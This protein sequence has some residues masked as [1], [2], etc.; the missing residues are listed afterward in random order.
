MMSTWCHR[1]CRWGLAIVLTVAVGGTAHAWVIPELVGRY[2]RHELAERGFP[3]AQLH[4]KRVGVD[5]VQ[6]TN[7]TLGDGMSLGEVELD[8]GW[9]LLWRP[10]HALTIRGA[11]IS[12][13]AIERWAT[14]GSA[15]SGAKTTSGPIARLPIAE[16]RLAD[17]TVD[18][19][20][21]RFTV[22]GAV[23]LASSAVHLRAHTPA[24]DV[25]PLALRSVSITA[26]DT[27]DSIRACASGQIDGI[28]SVEGCTTVP[29]ASL[30]ATRALDVEWS[31]SSRMGLVWDAQGRGHVAWK[32]AGVRVEDAV[33]EVRA[34]AARI[35]AF[36]LGEVRVHATTSGTVT[37][38]NEVRIDRTKLQLAAG[39]AAVDD[40]RVHDLKIDASVAGAVTAS[41]E[42]RIERSKFGLTAAT[43]SM[44]KLGLGDV[45]IDGTVA[46]ALTALTLAG[47]AHARRATVKGPHG[48]RLSQVS[49]PFALNARTSH[50]ELSL[51]ATKPAVASA[52]V[53]TLV[54]NEA[55]LR[56]RNPVI[57]LR[58]KGPMP[59]ATLGEPA[60]KIPWKAASIDWRGRTF[61]SPTGTLSLVTP[62]DVQHIAWK[63]IDGTAPLDL[64]RG[65][66]EFRELNNDSRLTAGQVAVLGGTLRL[67]APQSPSG[68]LML[69]ARGLSLPRV[70]AFANAHVEA[71]GVLDGN[72]VVIS[73]A[74]GTCDLHRMSLWAREP[75]VLRVKD[76]KLRGA[77][78]AAG[79]TKISGRVHGA[80]AD[81]GYKS[82][83]F[84]VA[85]PGSTPEVQLA[86]YGSGRLIKQS[87]DLVI[88]L[89]GLRDV[90]QTFSRRVTW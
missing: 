61:V 15:M 49:M 36:T 88:N 22:S 34:P 78:A 13:A 81:F 70:L 14:T 62:G 77:W 39:S 69:D 80:L 43:A 46:G 84:M 86:T 54:V 42:V 37:A 23:G 7:V 52:E 56:A 28:A 57:S 41:R 45:R 51:V 87:L 17:C 89:H 73:K 38:D 8:A 2:L 55:P 53:A 12:R 79:K 48:T 72:I 1:A 20:D 47:N 3:S 6:L 26:K 67:V 75:G 33:V 85:P 29:R 9:S 5:R 11:Q 65:F 10:A 66:A 21:T 16:L 59:M 25:G 27:E 74:P 63:R 90:M 30:L 24:W 40:L 32:D 64:G 76:P 50:G 19:G 83:T 35:G 82:L 31:A 4:V 60:S 58:P 71:T 44:R 18:L 68:E